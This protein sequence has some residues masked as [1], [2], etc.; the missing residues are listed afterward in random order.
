M[1]HYDHGKYNLVMG[2]L[3]AARKYID[4]G[5]GTGEATVEAIGK[6]YTQNTKKNFFPELWN[7]RNCNWE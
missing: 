4:S 5:Q 7:A 2:H 6:I 3:N 1:R